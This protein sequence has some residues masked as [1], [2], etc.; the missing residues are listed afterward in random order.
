MGERGTGN[1]EKRKRDVDYVVG[2][3]R[4][5]S[6]GDA[7]VR[8]EG[9][10]KSAERDL[11]IYVPNKQS[12][13]AASGDIVRLKV[14]GK[15]GPRGKPTGKVVD[16]VERATNVFVGT[17]DEVAGSAVVSV[18][19]KVFGDPIYV[20]DPGA[21]GV[22]IGDKVV[23]EMVRFPSQLRDGEG[24]I[25]KVLGDRG[26]PGVDT[27]AIKYEFGLPGDFPRRPSRL[28]A[29]KRPSSTSRSPRDAAT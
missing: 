5:I 24:V 16:I 29:K 2:T 18:D 7:F 23:I 28:P 6:S 15:P 10:P 3:L 14:S 12:A 22:A 26:E 21:K 9:T 17:Y 19:G 1:A 20:G 8:P 25:T 11:D 4:R 13:D 27:L